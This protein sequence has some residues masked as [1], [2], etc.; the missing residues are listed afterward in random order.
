[1]FSAALHGTPVR[2]AYRGRAHDGHLARAAR[3]RESG[4]VDPWDDLDESDSTLIMRVLLRL[5]GQLAETAEHVVAIRSFLEED[6]EEEEEDH[7]QP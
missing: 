1:V 5:E 4:G 7:P 6:D 3:V 2:G